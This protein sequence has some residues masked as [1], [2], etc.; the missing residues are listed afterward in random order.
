MWKTILNKYTWDF[1]WFDEASYEEDLEELKSKITNNT[2]NINSVSWRVLIIEWKIDNLGWWWT[3]E[4]WIWLLSSDYVYV[5]YWVDEG[6]VVIR[7]TID[8]ITITTTWMQT[9][10]KPITLA[11]VE[12]LSYS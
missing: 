9:W 10:T 2:I 6:W 5:I 3:L 4:Q 1:D 7:D 8:L 12:L 11:E